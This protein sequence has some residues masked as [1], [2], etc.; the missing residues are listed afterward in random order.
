MVRVASQPT[1]ATCDAVDERDRQCCARCGQYI[2][3]GSR[4]HRKLR[5]YGDH[6]AANLILLCGSG[7]TGCH[8]WVHA[9]PKLS[10]AQGWMIRGHGT[11]CEVP[12]YHRTIGSW[13]LLLDTGS[14]TMITPES[15]LLR[16]QL[17]GV[18]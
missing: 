10:Y 12:L 16:L 15:A 3:G 9:H 7:T 1:A 11:P 17:L 2:V 18:A 14:F 4:H 6:G 13:V 8:G 5:R